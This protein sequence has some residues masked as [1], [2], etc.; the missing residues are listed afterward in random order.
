[1]NLFIAITTM[2]AWCLF[3]N[4][5][6]QNPSVLDKQLLLEKRAVA[7]IQRILASE[8]DA[9]LPRLPFANWFKQVVG[10]EAGV[11]WQLSECGDILGASSN[12][13]ED[14]RACVEVNTILPD[15][16]KVVV[17]ITIGTFKKGLTGAPAFYIGVI[18]HEKELYTV[19]LLRDLPKLLW[20]PRNSANRPSINLPVVAMPKVRLAMNNAYVTWLPAWDGERIGQPMTIEAPPPPQ[21]KEQPSV[22]TSLP[23]NQEVSEKSGLTASSGAPKQ[24]GVVSWG[25]A[26]TKAQPRYPANARRVKASGPVDVQITISEEG[27]V[28]EAKAISGHP[29][30]RDAAVEASRKWVFKPAILN[31]VP[32]K[33]EIVLTFV[34]TV[35][36]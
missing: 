18:E 27:G 2:I 4:N 7:D 36:Q 17:M 10:A 13:T 11:V 16:R 6:P 12:S 29:L 20:T 3:L 28:I 1:M 21:V 22:A 8:L 9:D 32:V 24:S 23:E 30:L 34:F 15:S 26:I 35:P 19:Q 31:G 25:E 14:L 5:Q 33:T